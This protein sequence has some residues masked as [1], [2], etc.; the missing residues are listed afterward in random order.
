MKIKKI[1]LPS[2][3][4]FAE[5]TEKKTIVLHH[6]AGGH[7]PD[8]VVA[9]WDKDKAKGGKPLKVATQYIIGNISTR[10]K[11]SDWDGLVVE[12]F[13]PKMWAHHL[14][15][16]NSNNT[17]LN[18]QAIGIELCSYG[19]LTKSENGKF[20]TYVNSLVPEEL[21]VDLGKN[22]RGYRYYHTYSDKQIE[23]LGQLIKQLSKTFGIDVKKGL[24][25]FFEKKDSS[26]EE[27]TILE[28]QK[29][30]NSKGFVG[31]NGK[32]LT[33]DG[34]AGRNTSY[35]ARLYKD[36]K[37]GDIKAFE[38]QQLANE[39]AEGIWSHTNFR[40]DKFDV[41]PHPKLIEMLKSL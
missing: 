14:G 37:V 16:K 15:T 3:E 12:A 31:M 41:Y 10:D 9:T 5:E 8:W 1:H 19:G 23:S 18:Q 27:M 13:S 32:P 36:S 2:E 29:F 35:A 39:G 28:Q 30:L 6:T 26:F 7:R 24:V 25:Q 20:F 34:I 22:F 17:L 21:V 40:K 11:S 4:Y 33:E 38:F